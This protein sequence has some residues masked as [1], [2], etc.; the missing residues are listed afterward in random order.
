[1]SID[2]ISPKKISYMIFLSKVFYAQKTHYK[3]LRD[4]KSL[5]TAILRE[6]L[7]RKQFSIT[8][9]NQINFCWIKTSS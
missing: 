6:D 2:L 5:F 3:S 8:A 7:N 4:F 1:M 9:R